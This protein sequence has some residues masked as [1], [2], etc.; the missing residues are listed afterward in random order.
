MGINSVMAGSPVRSPRPGIPVF[1]DMQCKG[2][3]SV[4]AAPRGYQPFDIAAGGSPAFKCQLLLKHDP[5]PNNGLARAVDVAVS[6]YRKA[7]RSAETVHSSRFLTALVTIVE[8]GDFLACA[9][10]VARRAC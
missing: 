5:A 3:Q 7:A 8:F 9:Q 1:R 6:P 10:C 2:M 4:K